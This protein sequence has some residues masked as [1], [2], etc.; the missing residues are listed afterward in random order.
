V[1]ALDRHCHRPVRRRALPG[2][3]QLPGRS[4]GHRLGC[5]LER[6]QAPRRRR[7]GR[8][9]GGTVRRH[10]PARLPTGDTV[11]LKLFYAPGS[12]ALAA[13]IALEEAGTHYEAV[14][15]DLAAGD[16]TRPDYLR[17]TPK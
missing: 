8:R 2:R 3:E 12:C 14:R 7:I 17:V 5:A 16:Q 6:L 4:D 9:E 15:M 10:R 13:H 11:M 1:P